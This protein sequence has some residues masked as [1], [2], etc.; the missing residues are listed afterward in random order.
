MICPY[1]ESVIFPQIVQ[2][3]RFL[4]NDRNWDLLTLDSERMYLEGFLGIFGDF[5]EYFGF[6]V[7]VMM[8]D[9]SED[10]TPVSSL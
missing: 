4:L 3:K 5:S 8:G 7:R 6:G 9:K 2:F 1:S 10:D